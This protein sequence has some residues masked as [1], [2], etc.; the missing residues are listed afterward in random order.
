MLGMRIAETGRNKKSL[1]PG[2]VPGADHQKKCC[3]DG[4]DAKRGSSPYRGGVN[5]AW[6]NIACPGMVIH[7][8]RNML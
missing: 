4:K 1:S 2:V 6:H 5:L 8:K 7:F 3:Q